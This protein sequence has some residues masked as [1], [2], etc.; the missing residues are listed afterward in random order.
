MAANT[1]ENLAWTIDT[2][3]DLRRQLKGYTGC[4][5][6]DVRLACDTSDD[7]VFMWGDV[8][9]DQRHYLHCA[10]SEVG[11]DTSDEDLQ[12][13]AKALLEELDDSIAQAE[14]DWV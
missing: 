2:L 8:S 6:V 9:Y 4:A 5:E 3:T 10:A 7:L 13:R 14:S 12:E 11:A 1:P